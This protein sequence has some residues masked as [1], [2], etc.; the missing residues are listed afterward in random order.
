MDFNSIEVKICFK[1]EFISKCLFFYIRICGCIPVTIFKCK[2]NKIK[3]KLNPWKYSTACSCAWLGQTIVWDMTTTLLSI[4][5]LLSN[6]NIIRT[7]S[8]SKWCINQ[9]WLNEWDGLK[10]DAWWKLYG[11]MGG[12]WIYLTKFPINP[13]T[14]HSLSPFTHQ[15]LDEMLLTTSWYSFLT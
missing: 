15:R 11:Q 9:L 12:Y 14:M 2:K 3:G 8:I 10:L 5:E 1:I 7:T 6:Y 13:H 4:K